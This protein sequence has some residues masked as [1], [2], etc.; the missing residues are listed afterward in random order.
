VLDLSAVG[1]ARFRDLLVTATCN[2]TDTRIA[3]GGGG[4]VPAGVAQRDLAPDDAC[5]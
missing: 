5:R 3:P 1:L 4:I 2:G